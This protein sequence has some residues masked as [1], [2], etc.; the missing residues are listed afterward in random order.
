MSFKTRRRMAKEELIVPGTP[1]SEVKS[2]LDLIEA[3]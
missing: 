1:K 3:R 2:W